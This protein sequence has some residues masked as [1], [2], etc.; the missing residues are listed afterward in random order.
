MKNKYSLKSSNVL[1]Y[2][3]TIYLCIAIICGFLGYL[4]CTDY[5]E[6]NNTQIPEIALKNPGFVAWFLPKGNREK[7]NIIKKWMHG[8]NSF[9]KPTL[10]KKGDE[11]T[12]SR[13]F[14]L[15]TDKY[16]RD[17]YSRIIIGLRYTLLI[18][19]AS[20][21]LS[22]I[23]GTLLGAISG[24]FGGICDFVISF[25]ISIFWSLPT[26]L[27]AFIIL[28]VFGKNFWSIFIAIGLT[29]WGDLARLVR[30]QVMA[31]KQTNFVL[32]GKALGFTNIRIL[33]NHIFPNIT[34]P[35]WIQLSANFALA[36][37]LESGLSFLGLGLQPPIPTLGNIMQEQYSLI[38]SGK[39]IQALIPAIVVILLILSF[40][41]VTNHLRDKFDVKIAVK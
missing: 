13:T 17:I 2:F 3:A 14:V 25:I 5:T 40:Q 27:L 23:I 4:I 21:F 35:I 32:A 15:G 37:L 11:N 16:G 34:G 7:R 39:I 26:V 22:A 41:L 9:V 28:L 8:D 6:N 1:Y 18:G 10:A 20:V 31:F 19:F 36:I 12:V 38:F 24:Y 30:G 29:M 33:V